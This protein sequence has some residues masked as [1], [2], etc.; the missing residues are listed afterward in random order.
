M[1]A[2][3]LISTAAG[4]MDF[5]PILVTSFGTMAREK[6]QE[7]PLGYYTRV[8]LGWLSPRIKESEIYRY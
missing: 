2:N 3:T 7:N 1:A 5:V 8:P 4:G 6:N